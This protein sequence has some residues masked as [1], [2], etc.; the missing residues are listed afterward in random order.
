M[1]RSG[2]VAVV[3]TALFVLSACSTPEVEVFYNA[4]YPAFES[5]SELKDAADL[6]IEGKIVSST[7]KELDIASEPIGAAVEDPELNPGGPEQD[8][9]SVMVFT[10]HEVQVQRVLKGSGVEGSMVQVKE[11]GGTLGKTAYVAEEG[12]LL[13]DGESYVMFLETYESIPASLLNP[14]QAAY[15]KLDGKLTPMVG[16]SLTAADVAELT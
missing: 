9:R 11:L 1:M 16:N 4:S 10:V 14:I 13:R 6:V 15:Q 3:A 5:V 12:V 2:L 7:V 8:I